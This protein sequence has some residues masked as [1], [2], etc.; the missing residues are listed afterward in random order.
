MLK[1]QPR[2][3]NRLVAALAE[4]Y[5]CYNAPV[6]REGK[7]L[8]GRILHHILS[9]T[10]ERVRT[11]ASERLISSMTRD[12]RNQSVLKAILKRGGKTYKGNPIG[13]SL[14]DPYVRR[15]PRAEVNEIY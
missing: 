10:P 15:F 1:V 3:I 4:T 13:G 12:R 5:G 6:N 9:L 2:H 7:V 14:C 8:F 11:G